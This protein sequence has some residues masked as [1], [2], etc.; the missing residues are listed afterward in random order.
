MWRS[1]PHIPDASTAIT[2]SPSPGTGSGNVST[3]SLCSPWNTTAC[4]PLLWDCHLGDCR[5][6]IHRPLAAPLNLSYTVRHYMPTI[7]S[8]DGETRSTAGGRRSPGPVRLTHLVGA[9][10]NPW[11]W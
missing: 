2:T 9:L 11:M 5:C 6:S 1:E 8:Q 4:M 3:F 10:G 7:D